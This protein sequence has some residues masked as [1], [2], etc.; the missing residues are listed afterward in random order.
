MDR[1]VSLFS[2]YDDNIYARVDGSAGHLVQVRPSFEG[3]YE[4]PRMRLLGLYS[5]DAQRSNFATL[6]TLDARR[7]ALE[8]RQRGLG[9]GQLPAHQ[10]HQREAE[11]QEQQAG[12]GVLDADDLVVGGEDVLAPEAEFFVMDVVRGVRLVCV[13]GHVATSPARRT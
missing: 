12:D 7:H 8:Q 13:D 1:L 4:N 5:F 10:H 3:S 2:V 11:E 6:N 9:I